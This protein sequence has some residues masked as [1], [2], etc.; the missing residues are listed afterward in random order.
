MGDVPISDVPAVAIYTRLGVMAAQLG[1]DGFQL[2]ATRNQLTP[3]VNEYARISLDGDFRQLALRTFVVRPPGLTRPGATYLELETNPNAAHPDG[4]LLVSGSRPIEDELRL[5]AGHGSGEPGRTVPN[6][7]DFVVTRVGEFR[8]LLGTGTVDLLGQRVVASREFLWLLGVRLRTASL[9]EVTM[10]AEAVGVAP[11]QLA[12][13]G[14]LHGDLAARG[15]LVSITVSPLAIRPE[16]SIEYRDLSWEQV[17]STTSRLRG[18]KAGGGFGVFA[19]AFAA[20]RASCFEI[21]FRS[22]QV[23]SVRASVEY[24]SNVA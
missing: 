14:T 2:E 19:G 20:P 17:V 10:L 9:R 18:T 13:L 24:E 4:T 7:R 8:R 23:A 6:V 11:Y 1:I 21:T 15:C 12:M 22:S 16:L 5:L 3:A